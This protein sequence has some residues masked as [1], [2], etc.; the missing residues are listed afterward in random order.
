VK[1]ISLLVTMIASLVGLSLALLLTG[2]LGENPLEVARILVNGSVG[3]PT[4][5]GYSLFYATPLIFTGLSVSWALKAGLFNIGAEGQMTVGGIAMA[6][7]G[8]L[9]ADA[10]AWFAWPLA[11]ASGFAAGAFWGWLVGWFKLN[12]G[13]HEVL[14]SILLNFVSYGIA[15]LFILNIFR[16]TES[17]NPETIEV[18]QG[19]HFALLDWVGG[20]SPLNIAFIFALILAAI[21]DFILRRSKAGLYL[22]WVGGSPEFARRS[23]ISIS[24]E[25]IRAMTVSGGLAGLA[26]ASV[27]L[28]YMHKAREGFSGGAGFV[29]IAVALLGRGN[30]WGV[31]AAALLFGSLQKGSLDLDIDTENISRDLAVVIQALIVIAVA[32]RPAI[33]RPLR[34]WLE[35]RRSSG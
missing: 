11:L 5:F 25:S 23:G 12:R 16:N 15:G 29:G 7:T 27:V 8:I 2:F 9:I 30:A 24:K 31:V 34:E 32:A 17:A 21:V 13:V 28:G 26:G 19:F 6:A 10:S 33:E 20:T 22:R 3:S 35:R 1:Y 4:A 18:G 14:G